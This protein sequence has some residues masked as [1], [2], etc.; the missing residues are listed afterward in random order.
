MYVLKNSRRKKIRSGKENLAWRSSLIS[1]TNRDFLNVICTCDN[2][3]RFELERKKIRVRFPHAITTDYCTIITLA[4]WIFLEWRG[5]FYVTFFTSR[6]IKSNYSRIH[7]DVIFR[8]FTSMYLC[9][10][11]LKC[12]RWFFLN[13]KKRNE[14]NSINKSL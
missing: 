2:N 10:L 13:K 14:Y 3:V 1:N 8:C 9:L 6:K 5:S 4:P 12:I 11:R 7:A